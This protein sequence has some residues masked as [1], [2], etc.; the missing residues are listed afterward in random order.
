MDREELSKEVG[1]RQGC[2]LTQ[3]ADDLLCRVPFLR[4]GLTSFSNP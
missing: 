4:Q 1:T 2:R 3:L